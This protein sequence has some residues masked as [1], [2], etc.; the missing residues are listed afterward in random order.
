MLLLLSSEEIDISEEQLTSVLP[1]RET[2]V[3]EEITTIAGFV[4]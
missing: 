2:E 4:G 3:L 1:A